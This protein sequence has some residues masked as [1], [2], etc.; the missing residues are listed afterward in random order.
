MLINAEYIWLGGENPPALHSKT[1]VLN[2]TSNFNEEDL[3]EW[4]FNGSVSSQ[5][6]DD[7]NRSKT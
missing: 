7:C 4:G 3:P 1:M 5:G 6:D 2:L